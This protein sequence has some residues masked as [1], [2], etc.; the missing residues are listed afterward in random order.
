MGEKN[1]KF[2]VR[3]PIIIA[4]SLALGIVLG[5]YMPRNAARPVSFSKSVGKFREIMDHIQRN[6]VDEVETNEL[7]ETAITTVLEDL[8]PHSTYIPA[9]DKEYSQAELKGNFDG[10]GI[11]YGIFR[12]TIY[13]VTPLSGGPSEAVGLMTGDKI[14]EVDN[15]LVAGI[16][17][18]NRGVLDRLR[19]PKG[20][21][22]TVSILRKNSTSLMDFVIVRDKI[23]QFSVDAHYMIDDE[24][25]YIKVN[26]F[27]ATTYD[28][29]KTA[30]V[31]LNER[32]MQKLMLDL[33]GNPGGYMDRAISMVDELVAGDSMIVFTKG[34]EYRYNQEHRAGDTGIFEKRPLIVLID[35]GS[36]SAS[37]IVSGAIQDNDRG[38][39]VG[40][41]SF[42]KGL[43]QMPIDLSDGSELRLTISRYY[44]PSGRSIQ[45]EYDGNLDEYYKDIYDRYNSGEMYNEDSV[46]VID[47]LAFKTSKGR[48]VYGG[49]GIVPDHFVAIDTT[50][51]SVYLNRLFTSGS[52]REFALQYA[53]ENRSRLEDMGYDHYFDR[54]EVSQ[55]MLNDLI[56]LADKNGLKYKESQFDKSKDRIKIYLKA[57]I[58]RGIWDNNGFYPIWN[59]TNEIYVE[60]QKLFDEAENILQL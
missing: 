48:I 12:D 41:R 57:Q 36:A 5:A 18:T 3:L 35:E 30:L 43:V 13:V 19:G 31:D 29:F 46:K 28:E 33:T 25:G 34:K 52:I 32:G 8:D 21:E 49:G 24:V 59:Q 26:R 14:I 15:E 1:S 23:P 27:T 56:E 38:L 47:S 16:G 53:N 51:N 20:T 44:T 42:G 40:R 39:I 11:E 55:S 10:I 7:V 60:A 2:V 45:K 37:E 6:Y 17:I 54:F 9:K 50:G 22:V 58:A 4:V